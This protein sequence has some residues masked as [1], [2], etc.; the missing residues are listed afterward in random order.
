M[1]PI[2]ISN[3]RPGFVPFSARPLAVV[4]QAQPRPTFRPEPYRPPMLAQQKPSG[5]VTA[6]DFRAYVTQANSSIKAIADIA[7]AQDLS[8][9]E[10]QTVNTEAGKVSG[11]TIAETGAP[12]GAPAETPWL[13]VGGAL[14]AGGLVGSL[15]L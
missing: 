13:L 10:R 11:F 3:S 12:K 2:A 4:G 8:D 1:A 6:E 14:L 15:L 5:Y 9:E 7:R